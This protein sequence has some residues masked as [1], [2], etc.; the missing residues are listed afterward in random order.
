MKKR[1]TPIEATKQ[2]LSDDQILGIILLAENGLIAAARRL[3]AEMENTCPLSTTDA[4]KLLKAI[5]EE[6]NG[7]EKAK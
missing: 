2:F 5:I 1:L 7:A 4:I 3:Q 6:F